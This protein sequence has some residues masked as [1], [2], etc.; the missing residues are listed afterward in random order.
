MI[1]RLVKSMFTTLLYLSF[2]KAM[3]NELAVAIVS[4]DFMLS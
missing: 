4:V 3:V 2:A 1:H